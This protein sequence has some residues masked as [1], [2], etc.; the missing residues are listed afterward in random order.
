MTASVFIVDDDPS[1]RKALSRLFSAA[2]LPCQAYASPQAFLEA[3]DPAAPGC[4]VLDL[5]MPGMDGIELQ[6][7]LAERGGRRPIVFLTGRADVPTAVQ[8]MRAGAV[9]FLTKPVDDVELL[10]TVEKALQQ[11]ALRRRDDTA[12]SSLRE[13]LAKLTPREREVFA[14]VVGGELNKQIA[15]RLGVGEK[16]IKVHRAHVMEKMGANSLAELVRA[17]ERLRVADARRSSLD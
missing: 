14:H 4:L 10:R 2:G 6:R 9:D 16:T 12:A 1:V 15:S 13:R 5:A 11:D 7:Q 17:A 3:N 8:A